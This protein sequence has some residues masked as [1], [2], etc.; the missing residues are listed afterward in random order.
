MTVI[1][2]CAA[3]KFPGLRTIR[4]TIMIQFLKILIV[5]DCEFDVTLI[6]HEL[7][8]A[9]L[10]Y[11]SIVVEEKGP[12]EDALENFRPDVIL[13]DHFLPRFNSV[14]ALAVYRQHQ[15]R[16]GTA[17]PFILVTGHASE[18]LA[19]QCMKQGVDDYILKDRLRR[20]PFAIGSALDRRRLERER[21]MLAGQMSSLAGA[22]SQAERAGHFGVFQM[23][24]MSGQHVWS[25]EL[26]HIY[27][28]APGQIEPTPDRFYEH[29]CPEDRD[30]LMKNYAESLQNLHGGETDFRI[31]D[32]AGNVRLIHSKWDVVAELG[33]PVRIVGV[34]IDITPSESQI[35]EFLFRGAGGRVCPPRCGREEREACHSA[36]NRGY[37]AMAS[38]RMKTVVEVAV[39]ISRKM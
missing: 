12:F 36:R 15:A 2:N 31:S 5:E 10:N 14:E 37:T 23:D 22:G 7:T 33:I 19:V 3:Q 8:K 32:A 18:E 35:R 27:G 11:T 1:V 6:E 21:T 38:N 28:Y 17:I 16:C 13:V 9:G 34:N 20:L 29:V 26:Y 39:R 25:D 24:L 4:L 30:R